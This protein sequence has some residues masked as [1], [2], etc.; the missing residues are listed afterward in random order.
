METKNQIQVFRNDLQKLKPEI[1]KL[2]NKNSDRFIRIITSYVAGNP[3]LLECDSKSLYAALMEVAALDLEV[4]TLGQADLIPYKGKTK[5]IIGYQG[6]ITLIYRSGMVKSVFANIVRE[7]DKFDITFGTKGK[8]VHK[9]SLDMG[10]RIIGAYAYAELIS[11]GEYYDYLPIAE[12]ERIRKYS[13]SP[14]SLAWSEETSWMYRK[15][16]IRQLIKLLPKFKNEAEIIKAIKLDEAAEHN[17]QTVDNN[18]ETPLL[19]IDYLNEKKEQISQIKEMAVKKAKSEQTAKNHI[20][21]N[22]VKPETIKKE[23]IEYN[24]QQE[25]FAL[26]G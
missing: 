22:T 12:L 26:E 24:I 8:L 19:T 5:L 21:I 3:K 6:F 18:S 15:T 10:T 13:A 17:A 11:G 2:L 7:K 25:S 23:N 4:G 1:E 20:K 14:N 16:M 9:P